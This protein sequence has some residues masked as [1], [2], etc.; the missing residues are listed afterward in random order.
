MMQTT[1]SPPGPNST[2]HKHR[3]PKHFE[4]DRE[5]VTKKQK[6]TPTAQPSTSS[7]G[8]QN[9]KHRNAASSPPCTQPHLPSD[10][11]NNNEPAERQESN[12]ELI[13]VGNTDDEW[14]E[15]IEDDIKEL[16]ERENYF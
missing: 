4:D 7:T 1:K 2:Q 12:P 13:E 15:E 8:P 3:P 11:S 16:G 5:L 14:V 6:T 9:N 10:N